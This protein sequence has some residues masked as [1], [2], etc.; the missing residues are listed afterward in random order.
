MKFDQVDLFR[1]ISPPPGGAERFRRRLDDVSEPSR[2]PVA[3]TLVAGVA[4]IAVVFLM[5]TSWRRHEIVELQTAGLYQ[6]AEFDRL[7]GRSMA[8]EGTTVLIDDERVSLSEIPSAS[9]NIRIYE[10]RRN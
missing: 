1:E 5:T 6:A 9:E 2:F 8:R 4:V 10:I 3:F 7:L